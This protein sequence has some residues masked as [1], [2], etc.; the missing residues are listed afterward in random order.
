MVHPALLLR[1]PL[2]VEPSD[3]TPQPSAKRTPEE[4]FCRGSPRVLDYRETLDKTLGQ[5]EG[6]KGDLELVEPTKSQIS[7][8][9]R[10]LT[11]KH[12]CAV[13]CTMASLLRKARDTREWLTPTL[14][15]SAFLAR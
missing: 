15:S 3:L 7:S 5:K 13:N 11:E 1:D 10:L 9:R 12:P 14:K 8:I 4:F 6:K 2:A